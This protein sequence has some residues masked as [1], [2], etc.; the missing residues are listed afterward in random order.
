MEIFNHD[1]KIDFLRLRTISLTIS[2]ILLLISFGALFTR[3]LNYALDFTGGVLV[4]ATYHQQP[5]I[6]GVR[7]TL[8]SAGYH[9]PQVVQYVGTNDVAIRLQLG[10]NASGKNETSDDLKKMNEIADNVIA[11]LKAKTP[12]VTKKSAS[13]V[14][15]SVGEE[16]KSDGIVAVIFV[17]IGIMI[18]IGIRFEWRF[19]IA[20]IAS[21]FHDTIIVLGFY[22]LTGHDFDVAVL[23]SVLAVVGYSINDKVVVFDRVRELFRSARKAEPVE[24]LNKAIN[25]T[26]SRTIITSLFTGITMIALY[27]W[28]GPAVHGFA[29]TMIIGIIIGTLSSIFFA[30]PILYWLG[31]SK[32]DL[33]PVTRDNSE[34]ARR[35]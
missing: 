22:A 27:L 15:A 34:L 9:S 35:P 17:I 25:S 20:A 30:S 14:S 1:S 3:G 13:F 32:K 26:L 2:A 19:A 8:E 21:E 10:E 11:A 18:Y 12:D 5:D 16:L 28:G 6:D 24:I 4:E 31:V 7:A 29:L 33:M 23:A